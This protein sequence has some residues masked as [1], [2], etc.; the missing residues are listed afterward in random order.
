MDNDTKELEGAGVDSSSLRIGIFVPS[1][2]SSKVKKKEVG[3]KEN[4]EWKEN[5]A[6]ESSVIINKKVSRKRERNTSGD[7][8]EEIMVKRSKASTEED[9]PPKE[10]SAITKQ[11]KWRNNI[12]RRKRKKG[13]ESTKPQPTSNG[14]DRVSALHYLQQWDSDRDNWSFKKKTQYWLLQNVCDKAQVSL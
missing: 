9:L 5:E 10:E 14:T 6:T 12:S 1:V 8:S 11:R 13:Q 3:Y 4:K 2:V 7:G